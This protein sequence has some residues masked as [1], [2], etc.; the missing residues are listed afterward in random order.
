MRNGWRHAASVLLAVLALYGCE[1]M[2]GHGSGWTT[3][4][5]GSNAATL[6]NWNRV[7]DANW[8]VEDGAVV[9]DKGKGGYLV[10]KKAYG[11]C[12]IRARVWAAIANP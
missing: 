9:A 4:L 3:V 2:P 7:G 1:N 8:R 11:E 10:S 12:Q 5:D 6:A